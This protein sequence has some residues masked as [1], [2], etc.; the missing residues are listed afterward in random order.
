MI[1]KAHVYGDNIDTDRI[2]PGKYTKTL[3]LNQ[4][5]MHVMEDLDPEFSR[6]VVPG[7]IL[8]AGEN[9][10]CGSSREQAVLAIKAAE[11]SVVVGNSFARI[12]YRN[13]IN[14]GLPILEVGSHEIKMGNQ[15][16]VNLAT[17]IVH[18]MTDDHIYQA[19]KMPQVM[20]DILGAGGLAN[21]L[22]EHGDYGGTS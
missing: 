14:I 2:I 11:V 3:D 17:G 5:A 22:Q 8:V 20:V 10:G 12:F 18:D 9:F 4:L 15:L 16:E 21:Y 7:D 13:A 6:R 19:A 1:G